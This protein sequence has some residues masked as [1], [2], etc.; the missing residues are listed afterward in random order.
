MRDCP[1][2]SLEE[3]R[4]W[5]EQNARRRAATDQKSIAR[6]IAQQQD[7]ESRK[8]SRLIPLAAAKNLAFRGYDLILDF[9]DRLP[10]SV[11]ARCNPA[12]PKTAMAVLEAECTS[13]LCRA[14]D[15]YA[16]WPRG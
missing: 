1:T 9:V 13:I 4:E 5:R 16:L 15:A 14:Y 10:E 6:T 3:A 11:A 2:T 12:S 8:T 7:D